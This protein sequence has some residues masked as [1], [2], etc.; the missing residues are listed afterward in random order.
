MPTQDVRVTLP[1]QR[2]LDITRDLFA[3]M[4]YKDINEDHPYFSQHNCRDPGEE[5]PWLDGLM[6]WLEYQ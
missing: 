5:F 6:K 1:M 4:G 3:S 2:G